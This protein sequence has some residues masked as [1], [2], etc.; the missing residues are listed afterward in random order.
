MKNYIIQNYETDEFVNEFDTIEEAQQELERL[1]SKNSE[2]VY[3][4]VKREY[5][6]DV[7]FDDESASNNKG[8]KQTYDYCL[9]YI[10]MYNGTNESYFEDYKG[11]VVS[12]YC[13]NTQETVY[14][15]EVK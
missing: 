2:V 6:Y 11:G 13:N 4:I 5:T 8:W 7:C 3:E 12:I 15:E 9:S 1:E 14:E 10:K